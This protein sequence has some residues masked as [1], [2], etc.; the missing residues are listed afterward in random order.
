M[1]RLNIQKL[2]KHWYNHV[3]E[4]SCSWKATL[5]SHGCLGWLHAHV[6]LYHVFGYTCIKA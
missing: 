5:R 6:L 4:Y 1:E 3:E 2:R